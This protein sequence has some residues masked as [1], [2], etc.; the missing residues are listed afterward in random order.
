MNFHTNEYAGERSCWRL[1]EK[2]TS[3]II[4]I[5]NRKDA[6]ELRRLIIR[7]FDWRVKAEDYLFMNLIKGRKRRIWKREFASFRTV[8]CLY[9]E[10]DDDDG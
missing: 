3:K 9:C 10:H 4:G 6:V 8:S 7:I 2:E 1:G 5:A